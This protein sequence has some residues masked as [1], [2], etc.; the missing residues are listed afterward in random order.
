M[1]QF[2]DGGIMMSRPYFASSN[3]ILKMSNYKK[4]EWCKILDNLYYNF[5]NKH[6]NYLKRNYSTAIQV[7]FLELSTHWKFRAKLRWERL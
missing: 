2:S 5:I 3:Y 1:S 6:K 7:K 4:G